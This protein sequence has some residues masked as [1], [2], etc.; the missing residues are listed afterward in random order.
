MLI[1]EWKNVMTEVGD[2]QSLMNSLKQ[3]PY[4]P[5][6]KVEPLVS[7][8]MAMSALCPWQTSTLL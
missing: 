2:H 6:F 4:Y 5:L 8:A 7:T 1:K 3:S